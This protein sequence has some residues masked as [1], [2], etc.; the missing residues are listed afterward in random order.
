MPPQTPCVSCAIPHKAHSTLCLQSPQ[1][2][3]ASFVVSGILD[4]AGSSLSGGKKTSVPTSAH[5]GSSNSHGGCKLSD[6]IVLNSVVSGGFTELSSRF[7]AGSHLRNIIAVDFHVPVFVNGHV[8]ANRK[9][10]LV[11]GNIGLIGV[12]VSEKFDQNGVCFLSKLPVGISG[13]VEY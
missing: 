2:F 12:V 3:F 7:Y 10:G 9:E 11:V 6:V 8:I 13:N 1:I 4:C 5:R